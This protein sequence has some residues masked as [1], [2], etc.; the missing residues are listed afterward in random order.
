M[1]KEENFAAHP[2]AEMESRSAASIPISG[3]HQKAMVFLFISE[4]MAF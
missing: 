2:Q 4:A 1:G 3:I